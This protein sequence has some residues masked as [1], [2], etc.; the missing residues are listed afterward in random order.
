MSVKE[1]SFV[2]DVVSVHSFETTAA[3]E[4]ISYTIDNELLAA[5]EA[6]R[7]SSRR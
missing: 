7:S 4:E 2:S 5:D 3:L 6:S 1:R